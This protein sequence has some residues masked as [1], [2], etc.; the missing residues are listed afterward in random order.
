M[1]RDSPV[2][3]MIIFM[4]EVFLV[5]S[6][7]RIQLERLSEV[8]C[9]LESSNLSKPL[10]VTILIDLSS[11]NS[12]PLDSLKLQ[13]RRIFLE[14]EICDCLVEIDVGSLDGVRVLSGHLELVEVE[15]LWENFHPRNL[16]IINKSL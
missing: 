15:I 3:R 2:I 12:V 10:E 1:R 5:V 7:E 8:F 9:N 13:V 16:I 14:L 11:Q 6:I 4:T